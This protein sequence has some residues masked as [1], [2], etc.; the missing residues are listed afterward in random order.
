MLFIP[1]KALPMIEGA[2][3]EEIYRPFIGN[4]HGPRDI[5]AK[6]HHGTESSKV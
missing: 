6:L 1:S 5:L 4:L 3:L 2:W